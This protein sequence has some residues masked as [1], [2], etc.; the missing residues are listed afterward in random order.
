MGGAQRERSAFKLEQLA[1]PEKI[2]AGIF[3]LV[4]GLLALKALKEDWKTTG[5]DNNVTKILLGL[6][7]FGC[8]LVLAASFGILPKGG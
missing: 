5:L 8:V 2:F 4:I 6:M 1:T 3:A 7:A